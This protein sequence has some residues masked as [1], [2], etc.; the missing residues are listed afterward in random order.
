MFNGTTS[1]NALR[2]YFDPDGQLTGGNQHSL[3][4]FLYFDGRV[5]TTAHVLPGTNNNGGTYVP[6]AHPAWFVWD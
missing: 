1:L 5:T 4:I 2:F 6:G 3:G